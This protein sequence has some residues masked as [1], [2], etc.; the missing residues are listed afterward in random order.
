MSETLLRV[1]NIDICYRDVQVVW[2]A[3]LEVRKGEIVTVI[4]PNGAGKSTLLN[5][6]MGFQHPRKGAITFQ[7]TEIGQLPPE[8]VVRRGLTIVP[9]FENGLVYQVRACGSREKPAN[10]L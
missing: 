7:G 10:D 6:I 4:G 3:S 8:K 2:D 1:D 5:S 9:E